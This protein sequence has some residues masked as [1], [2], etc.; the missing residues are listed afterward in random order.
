V[1]P[2]ESECEQVGEQQPDGKTGSRDS[3]AA[4]ASHWKKGV[5]IPAHFPLDRAETGVI[6]PSDRSCFGI[7]SLGIGI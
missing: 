6:S 2:I 1:K 4:L 7:W 5:G 3:K